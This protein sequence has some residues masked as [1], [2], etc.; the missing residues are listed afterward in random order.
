[1]DMN[2]VMWQKSHNH[3]ENHLKEVNEARDYM[4][5]FEHDKANILI[6]KLM[7]NG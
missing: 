3:P 7:F 6:R 1:M 4:T 5:A 2:R